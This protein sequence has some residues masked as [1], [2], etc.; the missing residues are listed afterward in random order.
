MPHL[1]IA[2]KPGDILTATA[3]AGNITPADGHGSAT[4]TVT[5]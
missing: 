4:A 5:V 3:T 1:G 2:G